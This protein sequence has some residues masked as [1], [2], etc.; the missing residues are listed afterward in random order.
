MAEPAPS[1]M[2][3]PHQFVLSRETRCWKEG[4]QRHTCGAFTL[5]SDPSLPVWKLLDPSGKHVGF[6]LGWRIDASA[7]LASADI[8]IPFAVT[9][10]ADGRLENLIYSFGGRFV[11]AILAEQIRRV[12]PDAG[13]TLG[14]VFSAI[15]KILGSTV[16]VLALHHPEHPV[17]SM[18]TGDFPDERPNQYYPAGLTCDSSTQRLLPNHYVDLDN[19]EAV[20]HYPKHPLRPLTDSEIPDAVRK[21]AHLLRSQIHAA[22]RHL[23]HVY[24]PLTAGQDSRMLLACSKEFC[25]S[26]EYMTFDYSAVNKTATGSLARPRVWQTDLLTSDNLAKQG[27]LNHRVVPV[28]PIYPQSTA[29]EYLRRIGFAGGAGKS[30]DFF[31]AC[32]KELEVSAAWITGFA[33]AVAKAPYRRAGD[34]TLPSLGADDVLKRMRLP[35]EDRFVKATTKWLNGLQTSND[36]LL[37]LAHLEH[38]CGG[39]SSPHMYGTAPF[40]MSLAPFCH[41][42]IFDLML[43]LPTEYKRQQRLS[44]DLVSLAWPAL[45]FLPFNDRSQ[46][47]G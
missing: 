24:M 16:S 7:R 28:T 38:R 20:R 8:R 22:V 4:W 5:Q 15:G 14:V 29:I 9:S 10:E 40:A 35:I 23:P 37:D 30:A 44:K 17:W 47:N 45:S 39:W 36:T 26:I 34:E 12:Y 31:W 13:A 21:I 3:Y 6:A 11:F 18:T 2:E 41:R 25:H 33:G 46:A 19:W 32:Q 43:R 42:T 1:Q 27:A